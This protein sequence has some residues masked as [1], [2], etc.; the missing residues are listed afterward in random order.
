M[1]NEEIKVVEEE[2]GA[3]DTPTQDPTPNAEIEALKSELESVKSQLAQA[4]KERD[5]VNENVLNSG[6]EPPKS[7]KRDLSTILEDIE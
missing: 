4:I 3:T 2:V 5:E 1:E 7:K 6:I